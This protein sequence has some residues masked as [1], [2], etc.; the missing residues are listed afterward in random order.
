M[1]AAGGALG[2]SLGASLSRWLGS[3]DYT[4]SQN[5][6]VQK[7]SP[8]GTIPAMHAESQTIVV[9]HKEYI[10]PVRGST[11]F[12]VQQQFALNPGMSETFPW[13]SQVAARFQ[14]YRI[15][16]AVYHYVPTSGTAVSGSNPALGSV[17]MQTAYRANESPPRSK[18][19]MMNEYWS[20]E[21][22]PNEAFCHPIEC[23]PKE[24]PFN[25]QYVRNGTIPVGDS[26]L[27]YDAGKTFLATSGMPATGNIVG[28]LWITYEVELRKPV[29]ES[30]SV[31]LQSANSIFSLPPASS[32][33][34]RGTTVFTGGIN[35]YRGAYDYELCFEAEPGIYQLEIYVRGTGLSISAVGAV[36]VTNCV[37]L[38]VD[39]STSAPT[40][41]LTSIASGGALIVVGVVVDEPNVVG[42]LSFANMAITIGSSPLSTTVIM[43]RR[44][45]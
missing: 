39:Q 40:I 41:Q 44:Q 14:E 34:F 33:A 1:P 22:S 36:T 7:M 16:G 9:R 25:V 35:V 11:T 24:N 45:V 12:T 31:S 26:V 15:R 3:G 27:M 29:L 4:V 2:T 21:A 20:S 5:S 38:P 18:V 37:L 10:G 19:E 32:G 17:M 28:D 6:I 8:N 42:K 43:T 30:N 23:N 13:L